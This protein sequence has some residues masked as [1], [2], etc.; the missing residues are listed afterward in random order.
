MYSIFD[1]PK[2]QGSNNELY[3]IDLYF[4][5]VPKMANEAISIE[6]RVRKLTKEKRAL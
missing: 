5:L 4:E 2:S 1:K 3:P 6:K